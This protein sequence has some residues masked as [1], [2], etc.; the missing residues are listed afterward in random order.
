MNKLFIQEASFWH[1]CNHHLK[2]N[3]NFWASKISCLEGHREESLMPKP[4]TQKPPTKEDSKTLIFASW[5]EVIEGYYFSNKKPTEKV[6]WLCIKCCALIHRKFL[7]G[8]HDSATSAMPGS[9][10][11]FYL[12]LNQL[13]TSMHLWR[14]KW[15][16][17]LPLWFSD[18]RLLKTM[19]VR[20]FWIFS[21]MHL[22]VCS[23]Q[24]KQHNSWRE[25]KRRGGIRPGAYTIFCQRLHSRKS[26][27]SD[28]DKESH[29]PALNSSHPPDLTT[30]TIT[31]FR[32]DKQLNILL[33]LHNNT[34]VHRSP[35]LPVHSWPYNSCC[36]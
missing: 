30:N 17:H 12:L 19:Q 35:L 20:Y 7:K 13:H 1:P 15:R 5:R 4:Y 24:L 16:R 27:P 32:I 29:L 3:R 18:Y 22:S 36:Y 6:S 28:S 14:P 26:E 23:K 21:R 33:V 9:T 8:F 2:E 10:A 25:Q 34:S 31:C 11:N